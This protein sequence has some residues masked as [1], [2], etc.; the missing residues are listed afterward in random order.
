TEYPYYGCYTADVTNYDQ[1]KPRIKDILW[2]HLDWL[3][4]MDRTGKA[5]PV[6]LDNVHKTLLCNT[7]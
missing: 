4:E 6:V 2:R 5:R 1:D 3:E 7:S